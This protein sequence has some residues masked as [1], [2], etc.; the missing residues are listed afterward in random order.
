MLA[1]LESELQAA[2]N[3]AVTGLVATARTRL[4]DAAAELATE[5]ALGLATVAEESAKGL[6]EVDARR[7]EFHREVAAMQ[8]HQEKQEGR[9]ELNIGG[10]RFETSVQTLRRVLSRRRRKC[11]MTAAFSWTVMAS[12]SGTF[13]STCGTA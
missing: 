10:Y 6:A 4:E 8:T 5:R 7:A 13:W 11:A 1:A 12:T 3:M 2:L 9:V